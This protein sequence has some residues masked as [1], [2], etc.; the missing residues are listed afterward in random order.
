MR[1]AFAYEQTNQ[2]EPAR[3]V[4]DATFNRHV[5]SPWRVE[6]RYGMP[7]E[8]SPVTLVIVVK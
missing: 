7:A 2:W 1:L 6:A 5:Q 4:Y 3:L 8:G